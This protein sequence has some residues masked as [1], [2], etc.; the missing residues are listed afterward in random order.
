MRQENNLYKIQSVDTDKNII[1][2]ELC[3][4]N[5]IYKAHFPEQPITPGVC[6]IQMA[7][8]L[9]EKILNKSLS[10]VEVKNAKF[11]SVIDPIV[12]PQI[13]YAFQRIITDDIDCLI[14]ATVIVSSG[15]TICAKL[16]LCYRPV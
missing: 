15:S 11:V 6:I 4:D 13:T 5:I 8:E 10:L 1:T 16:S 14:R 3:A 2:L 9:L 12:M 7:S